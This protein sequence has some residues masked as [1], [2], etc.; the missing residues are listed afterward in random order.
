MVVL[1][2]MISFHIQLLILSIST[3]TIKIKMIE[4]IA[5]NME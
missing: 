5:K 2:R 3:D 4:I 1:I